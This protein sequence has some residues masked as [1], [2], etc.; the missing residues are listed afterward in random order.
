M[1]VFSVPIGSVFTIT[2]GNL[3]GLWYGAGMTT[4]ATW[5]ESG[6]I[7][8]ITVDSSTTIITATANNYGTTTIGYSVSGFTD[9]GTTTYSN[10]G[11]FNVTTSDVCRYDDTRWL[12][13]TEDDD[14]NS[15]FP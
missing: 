4:D 2:D 6:G 11:I 1:A 12:D 5:T 8:T 9:T 3:N 13:L 10:S 7:V 15:V 14:L